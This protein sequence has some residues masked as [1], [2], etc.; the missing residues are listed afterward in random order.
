MDGDLQH[1]PEIIPLMIEHWKNGYDVALTKTKIQEH[2]KN[3]WSILPKKI[4]Y[5]F[6]SYIAEIGLSYGQSDFQSS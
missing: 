2:S 5:N 6:M 3:D 1:P 4:F